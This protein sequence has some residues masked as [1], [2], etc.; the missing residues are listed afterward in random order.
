MYSFDTMA[1]NI[2]SI[3]YVMHQYIYKNN[4]DCY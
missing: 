4:N 3:L 2:H 1:R